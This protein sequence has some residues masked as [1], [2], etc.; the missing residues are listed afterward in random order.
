MMGQPPEITVDELIE[1]YSV[2][3]LDSDGVLIHLSKPLPGASDLIAKLNRTGK[4]YYILTN[5]ASMLPATRA[6]S[7]Q[8]M[9]LSIDS[10]RII[11][12]GTLL[13]DYFEANHLKGANCVVL[14]PRDCVQNVE[15]AGGVVVAPSET[16]DVLVVGDQTGFPFL[17]TVDTVLS[18]LL[19]KLDRHEDLHLVLPNPDLIYPTGEGSFGLASGSVA[20]LFE[21]A[22]GLRYPDRA[23]L[24][25]HRLGKPNPEIFA[26]AL[27]RSG[28]KDMV[29]VGDSLGTDICGANA[30]GI[31]SVLVSTGVTASGTEAT[32]AA[33]HPN[34]LMR[35]LISSPSSAQH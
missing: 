13:S 16:F 27:R 10:A 11:T 18:A 32:A 24:L 12:S 9:G 2:L 8:S 5:D 25:F 22:L 34:F 19:R 30:F 3:L 20:L 1:R 33:H 6:E 14:G 29:M 15:E 28:T 21:S 35:S 31:A 26:E 7:Y 4:P 23:G 17:E